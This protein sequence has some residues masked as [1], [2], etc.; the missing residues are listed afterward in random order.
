MPPIL[1]KIARDQFAPK[2]NTLKPNC[3]ENKSNNDGGKKSSKGGGKKSFSLVSIG[4]SFYKGS[5]DD[6]R[7]SRNRALVDVAKCLLAFGYSLNPEWVVADP[8]P[9]EYDYWQECKLSLNE[10]SVDLK[11]ILNRL[12]DNKLSEKIPQMNSDDFSVE[13]VSTADSSSNVQTWNLTSKTDTEKFWIVE[14]KIVLDEKSISTILNLAV[15]FIPTGRTIQLQADAHSAGN[16]WVGMIASFNGAFGE[17]KI[18]FTPISADIGCGIA[19]YPL[20]LS[21]DGKGGVHLNSGNLTKE[22]IIALKVAVSFACRT[23]LARGKAAEDGG[24]H[25]GLI[26]E[27]FDFIDG[28]KNDWVQK[29]VEIFD[30]LQVDYFN[31]KSET[32]RED[33]ALNFAMGF[34]QTLGSSGNHFLE[35]SEDK[36]GFLYFVVHSGSRGLGAML[37]RRIA[38][39]C[40]AAYGDGA[41][42]TGWMADLYKKVFSVC[43]TFALLN[44]T[45]CAISVMKCLDFDYT[46]Q[47]LRKSL[48]ETPMFQIEGLDESSITR[49]MRGVVHNNMTVFINHFTKEM[50]YIMA[51]GAIACSRRCSCSIVAL[52]AGE[53]CYAFTLFDPTAQWVEGDLSTDYTALGYSQITDLNTTD[54][55]FAGHGAGRSGSATQTWKSTT[56]KS[57]LDYYAQYSVFGNLSPNVLGDNPASAYKPLSEIIPFLPLDIAKSSTTL[58][59]LVSH[60][61][62][63]DHRPEWQTKFVHFVRETFA[64]QNTIDL[65]LCSLDINLVKYRLCTDE[66]CSS[67]YYA[68]LERRQYEAFCR[69]LDAGEL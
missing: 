40:V 14:S 1:S 49:L 62:G 57:I 33:Q 18:P 25:P 51:K 11:A 43:N 48:L 16:C 45:L 47:K 55:V 36:D 41:V 8:T 56:F 61:E 23:V 13:L 5:N 27:V 24:V 59:T 31:K 15:S 68:D 60:K 52:R 63:I 22:Q 30:L 37:Y 2:V 4:A 65:V 19:M 38:Q 58:K 35:M 12:R 66:G 39:L 50:I 32:S 20:S 67:D 28:N 69:I 21:N 53:G 42:A 3:D 6:Y 44:R 10:T 64:N 17:V 46:G 54:I 34:S 26:S 7:Q 29:L 9:K